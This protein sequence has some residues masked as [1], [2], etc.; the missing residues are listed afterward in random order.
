MQCLPLSSRPAH[1]LWRARRVYRC[2]AHPL[3]EVA[4]AWMGLDSRL[5]FEI[6]FVLGCV[7]AL[8]LL[9][10]YPEVF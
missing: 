8:A 3:D 2:F 7:L 9:L 10:F 1:W 4:E 5:R 6:K